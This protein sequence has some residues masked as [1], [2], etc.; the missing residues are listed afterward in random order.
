MAYVVSSPG[1]CGEFIQGYAEGASFMVTC[2]INRYAMALVDEKAEDALPDKAEEALRK[3]LAYLGE[4]DRPS[5]RLISSI[6]KGKRIS[7]PL[8]RPLHFPLG[9]SYRWR[10]SL[11]LRFL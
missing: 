4:T 8:Q 9:G 6:P 5:V 10:R 7:V 11:T 2:P 3:T 1:S